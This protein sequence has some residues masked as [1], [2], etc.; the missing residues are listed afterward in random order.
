MRKKV[1]CLSAFI[2]S[3][4]LYPVI[5]SAD[6]TVK[7]PLGSDLKQIEVKHYP[8]SNL[9]SAR[10]YEELGVLEE[11]VPV[12]NGEAKISIDKNGNSYYSISLGDKKN[13]VV[14][15]SPGDEILIEIASLSPYYSVISGS[16]IMDGITSFKQQ[17]DGITKEVEEIVQ[18]GNQPSMEKIDSI[19]AEI[20]DSFTEFIEENPTSPLVA[21]ALLNLEDSDFENYYSKMSEGAKASILYPFVEKRVQQSKEEYERAHKMDKLQS[22]NVT[23]PLF[24]LENTYGKK[25]SLVDFKGKWVILDFWGSWCI[26]CIKGFPELKEAYQKYSGSLEVIGIDCRESKEAWL[27]GIKKYELPWVNL[28]CP[29]GSPLLQEYGVQGFPTKVIIDPEGKVRNITVGHNPDFFVTLD[30]LMSE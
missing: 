8:L 25:V 13:D 28:Y 19:R 21:Y 10:N 9:S 2:A 29:E 27:A 20:R 4:L 17:M 23:A 24:S 30:S 11:K 6:I 18:T 15:V 7:L 14:Y 3:T 1:N 5:T 22:G 12:E 16:V 26:W